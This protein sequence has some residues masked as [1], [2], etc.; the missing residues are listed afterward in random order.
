VALYVTEEQVKE[1]LTPA[2]AIAAVDA[3]FDRLARGS[4]DNPARVRAAIPGGVFAVMPCVDRELGY[5]GLKSYAWLEHG[6]PFAIV[7]FS[8]EH[9]RLEAVIE[10]DY[11]GQLRT[12]AASAVAARRLAPNARTLGVFGCGRQAV[13]HVAALRAALPIERV[14]VAGRDRARVEAFCAEHGCD[15]GDPSACDVVVTVTTA[16]EPVLHGAALSDGATV[17]AVG[18]NDPSFRELDDAV[19]A[20]ATLVCCDSIEQSKLEAGD[21]IGRVDWNE[22]RELQDVRARE[23]DDGV[24][25][26]K[27]NGLAAWDLAVAARIVELAS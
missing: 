11:L 2:D 5:A 19:L 23:P 15:A 9:A 12:A 14:V 22:V 4:I 20:R 24:V 1:L 13:S 16:H 21:L 3:S 10:A 17:I 6:T 8:I 26:F 18:A 25:V 27:S 7:L